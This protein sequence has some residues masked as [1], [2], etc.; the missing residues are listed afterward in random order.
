MT[1]NFKIAAAQVSSVGGDVS[2][3][4]EIHLNAVKKAYSLGISYLVFPE[5]SITGY[6]PKLS[7]QLAFSKNDPRLVPLQEA[8]VLYKY[9]LL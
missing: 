7:K 9:I 3:N 8:A 5:L 1:N 2:A 4:I 6:E